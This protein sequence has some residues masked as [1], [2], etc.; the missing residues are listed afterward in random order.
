V[1]VDVVIVNSVMLAEMAGNGVKGA[2]V[3]GWGSCYQ[4]MDQSGGE[5]ATMSK[6]LALQV[7]QGSLLFMH[8]V[9]LIISCTL[10]RY[11]LIVHHVNINKIPVCRLK[12][13][14]FVE[15]IIIMRLISWIHSCGSETV[16]ATVCGQNVKISSCNSIPSTP[17]VSVECN[18][19]TGSC[20]WF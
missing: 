3:K 9:R 2:W 18:F 11:R 8:G 17:S 5:F 14:L 4:A 12:I 20:P 1:I 7:S 13:Y 6:I 10:C 16:L 15:C 19:F